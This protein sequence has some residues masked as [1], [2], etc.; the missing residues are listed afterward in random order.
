MIPKNKNYFEQNKSYSI[1]YI[2]VEPP[3][4]ILGIPIA[5]KNITHN[6]W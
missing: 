4:H 2:S 1:L 5:E 6:S 3:I